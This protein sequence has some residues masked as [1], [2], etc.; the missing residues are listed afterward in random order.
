MSEEEKRM[1][2]QLVKFLIEEEAFLPSW[3]WSWNSEG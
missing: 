2:E 1:I 3:I